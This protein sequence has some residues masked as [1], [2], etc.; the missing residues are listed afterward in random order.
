M[1]VL[2]VIPVRM[3]SSRFP[4]K[5]MKKINGK[6]MVSLIYDNVSKSKLASQI[7]VA[8][9]DDEIFNHIKMQNRNVVMTSTKHTR[10]TERTAEALKICEKKYK[11]K[12]SI[13]VMVQGDEPMIDGK[14]IDNSIKPFR[15]KKVNV[16][17]LI[18]KIKNKMD[19]LDQNCI[20]VTKDKNYNALYFSRSGIPNNRISVKY[21]GYKQVCVIPFRRNFLLNY[22]KMKETYLEKIESIDMLRLLENN[23]KVKL[24][25]IFKETYPVDTKKDLVKINKILNKNN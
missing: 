25:E 16:V 1:T 20:K 24:V 19:F 22:V 5:P 21:F 6:S 13:V 4:G 3:G 15:N 11:K 2:I 9:C 18:S 17:N 7:V 12:Y 8:T 14:M 10:A 23:H